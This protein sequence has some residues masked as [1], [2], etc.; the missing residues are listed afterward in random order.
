MLHCLE[1][2]SYRRDRERVQSLLLSSPC[3]N[4]ARKATRI[5]LIKQRQIGKNGH[6][7][8]A[9]LFVNFKFFKEKS[10]YFTVGNSTQ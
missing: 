9:I 1:K 7:I 5:P 2:Q 4:T 10:I 3:F 6:L 8:S